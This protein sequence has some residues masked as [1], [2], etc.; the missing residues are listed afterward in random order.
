MQRDMLR[1][2]ND[3]GD[4]GLDSLLYGGCRLVCCDI[5]A[6][7]IGLEN[8]HGLLTD[9][10]LVIITFLLPLCWNYKRP[11]RVLSIIHTFRTVGRT[12]KPRCSPSKPGRTP[13]TIL[14]PHSIDSLALAVACLP[15]Q[16]LL[17][18]IFVEIGIEAVKVSE[19]VNP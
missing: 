19:P 18:L 7:R 1:N 8:F 10:D 15:V 16:L 6:G 2:D 17:I 13:P 9:I 4:L 14:V 3:Q 5:D 11:R 12:G